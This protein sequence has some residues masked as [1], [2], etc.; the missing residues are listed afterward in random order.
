MSKRTPPEA[1]TRA[2]PVPRGSRGA[3]GLSGVE[4]RTSQGWGV[5]TCARCGATLVLGDETYET[6]VG[7]RLVHICAECAAAT[8]AARPRPREDPRGGRTGGA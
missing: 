7:G 3:R 1:D 5:D 2:R 6:R 4:P 8:G